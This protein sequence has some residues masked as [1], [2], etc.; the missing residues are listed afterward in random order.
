[1]STVSSPSV[2]KQ[3][4][5]ENPTHNKIHRLESTIQYDIGNRGISTFILPQGELLDAAQ[6]LFRLKGTSNSAALITGFPCLID[7]N[8]PTETDGPLGAVAIARSFLAATTATP[9]S[10]NDKPCEEE[11][12]LFF[13]TERC[14]EEVLRATLE[15]AG[16]LNHPRLNFVSFPP[17]KEW[18]E[19]ESDEL[20][21]I[22]KQVSTSVAI[23]RTGPGK[24][25][26]YYTMR[27]YDMTHMLAPLDIIMK[28]RD[29]LINGMA[30]KSV[31]IGDGGNE[32]GMGKVW[33][34][35]QVSTVPH[36]TKIAC[37]VAADHLIVCGVSN[38]G[39]NALGAAITL[40]NMEVSDNATKCW[41]QG[42][43]T[44]AGDIA[45]LDAMVAVG[46]RDG[47]SR[48]LEATV[49]GFP[50]EESLKIT[51]AIREISVGE[52]QE[53]PL[54][55]KKSD[56]AASDEQEKKA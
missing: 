39:G 31:G 49:D 13:L 54:S 40:L 35:I 26:N 15:S 33:D 2:K 34:E 17:K 4:T 16:L 23:E 52:H 41:E 5:E 27:G 44:D 37:V 48:K 25:G 18:T 21:A 42:M 46:A 9:S 43:T 30:F 53:V 11:P 3:K 36:A 14:N 10:N 12:T 20:E 1:M 51:R 28:P 8:P 50:F 24:D 32:V 19:K 29:T 45:I 55:T 38:W 6:S 47:C 7:C 22:S 56:S